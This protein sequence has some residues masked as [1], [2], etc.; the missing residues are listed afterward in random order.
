MGSVAKISLYLSGH[1]QFS[2]TSKWW[3]NHGEDVVQK[4]DR[5][6]KRW[7][8]P[9]IPNGQAAHVFQIVIPRSELRQFD[10]KE[11]LKKVY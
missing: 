3:I 5:H 10:V 6:F 4:K 9:E 11:N 8:L 2:R 7:E 1:Y